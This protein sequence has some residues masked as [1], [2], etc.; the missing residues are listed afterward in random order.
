MLRLFIE[1]KEEESEPDTKIFVNGKKYR[2]QKYLLN[3]GLIILR[4]LCQ[5]WRLPKMS[6]TNIRGIIRRLQFMYVQTFTR[7]DEV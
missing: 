1:V 5:I 7:T 4:Y 2:I 3:G 6:W